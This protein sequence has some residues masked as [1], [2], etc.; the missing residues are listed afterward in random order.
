M[1]SD[2]MRP[3]ENVEVR[4]GPGRGIAFGGVGTLVLALIVWFLGGNPMAVLSGGISPGSAPTSAAQTQAQTQQVEFVKRVLGDTEDV[5][6][7]LFRQQNKTYTPARLVIFDGIT[8]TGCGTAQSITGPFYCPADS[9]LYIDLSFYDELSRR[10]GAPGDFA[11]AYVIAHEVGHHVQHLLG[12]T[13]KVE[14]M[15]GRLSKEEANQLSV[16]L[17][18]QADYFAGVWAH[19]AKS[20]RD[21]LEKGD[22]EEGLNAAAAI[23]D[24]RL[25]RQGQGRVTPDSF[26]HGSSAQRVRWFKKGFDSGDMNGGDTFS[27]GPL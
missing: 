20:A 18:L 13:D 21:I 2:E 16:R 27:A 5:W 3:S 4:R 26:T 11:Q 22:L 24:D 23:G 19:H 8:D 1:R 15:R 17:E 10:F 14:A 12:T 6:T 7:D 25:Q 9:K